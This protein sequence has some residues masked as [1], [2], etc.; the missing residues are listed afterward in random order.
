MTATNVNILRELKEFNEK[1]KKLEL[2]INQV[3]ITVY[4]KSSCLRAKFC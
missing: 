1:M 4:D 3:V 2:N